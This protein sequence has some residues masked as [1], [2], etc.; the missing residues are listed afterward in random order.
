MTSTAVDVV[1]VFLEK[2]RALEPRSLL[3]LKRLRTDTKVYVAAKAA[4]EEATRRSPEGAND[5][6]AMQER[7]TEIVRAMER[8]SG[9][10]LAT[11]LAAVHDAVA[12]LYLRGSPYVSSEL[13][14][15][16]YR[17]LDGLISTFELDQLTRERHHPEGASTLKPKAEPAPS[18]LSPHH[19]SRVRDA[20][21]E[22]WWGHQ[23]WFVRVPLIV[24]LLIAW[25]LFRPIF[26]T[27]PD[28]QWLAAILYWGWLLF[29][30]V[31]VVASI[32][33]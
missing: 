30:V 9:L 6:E 28:W 32:H 26:K 5:L 16:L 2:L 27:H 25:P 10:S 3:W 11:E 8:A 14:S 29:L 21:W 24:A 23:S 33:R 22:E 1:D 31:F 15:R 13:P 20:R 18:S 7:A 19:V 12:G 17:P 4:I